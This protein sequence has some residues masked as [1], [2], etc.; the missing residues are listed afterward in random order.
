MLKDC[1]NF[2]YFITRITLVVFWIFLAS[3][4]AFAEPD[5]DL[6]R[7]ALI[8]ADVET[9]IKEAEKKQKTLPKL[10]L[11]NSQYY[12][13]ALIVA[14]DID[15]ARSFAEA[16]LIR[17]PHDP[18]LEQGLKQY[19][20]FMQNFDKPAVV[21]DEEEKKRIEL[22]KLCSL[23]LAQQASADDLLKLKQE[24]KD[25]AALLQESKLYLPHKFDYLL[26]LKDNGLNLQLEQEALALIT[27]KQKKMFLKPIDYY[28]LAKSYKTLA[29]LSFQ[30]GDAEKAISF[31]ELGQNNI[32]KMRSIWIEEDIIVKR[33]IL[34]I[35]KR[36]TKF[37]FVLP[38]WLMLLRT[39]FDAYLGL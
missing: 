33:K 31:V 35:D 4:V 26:E 30:Q 9:V 22:I 29:V 2:K 39:E 14:G 18:V 6:M 12:L 19:D 20:L 16:A 5:P 36:V 13:I 27:Q 23:Y 8:V 24:I 17:Y 25:R 15:K 32:Y 34:K 28:D 3:I 37:G 38:Q 21:F 7:D 11:D 10:R 1:L